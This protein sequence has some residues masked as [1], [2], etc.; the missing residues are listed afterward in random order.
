MNFQQLVARLKQESLRQGPAPASPATSS[1]DDA[2]LW[3]LVA[4]EWV[5]LQ[6]NGILWRFM[7]EERVV[8]TVAGQ[9]VYTPAQLT[10]EFQAPWPSDDVYRPRVVDGTNWYWMDQELSY[11]EF[12]RAFPPG[13]AQGVPV[14]YCVSPVGNLMLGPTPDR[15]LSI[16]MD[17][18]RAPTSL[19]APADVPTG[20][21]IAHQNLLVWGALKRVAIIDAASEILSR[22]NTEY[23][24]DWDRLW[25]AQGPALTFQRRS[26]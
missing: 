5:K 13:H 16:E 3:A 19:V 6:T 9:G 23:S 17:F 12:R 26:L 24:E 2:Q 22:A 14:A 11:D 10:W 1:K 21:P 18:L 25:V 15:V 4:D 20:L 7:R 8:T